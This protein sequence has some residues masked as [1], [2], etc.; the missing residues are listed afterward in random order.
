M[1]V[2]VDRE[3]AERQVELWVRR[4]QPSYRILACYT[5]LPLVLTPELVNYLWLEFLRDVVPWVAG[6]DLLLSELCRPV[7][8]ELYAMDS[9]VRSHLLEVMVQTQDDPD[10]GRYLGRSRLQ[11]V[12][13]KLLSFVKYLEQTEGMNADA[14]EAQQWAA[15]VYLDEYRGQ[16]VQDI[17]AAF[18]RRDAHAVDRS[19]LA[20]LSHITAELAPELQQYPNLVDYARLV[21]QML[22]NPQAVLPEALRIYPV[23]GVELALPPEL[24]PAE[25]PSASLEQSVESNAEAVAGFP[26]LQMVQTD[27]FEAVPLTVEASEEMEEQTPLQLFEFTTATIVRKRSIISQS[28]QWEIQRSQGA[29]WQFVET[30]GNGVELEMV[31]IPGG[32]FM[33]GSPD[34]EPESYDDEKPR[35]EVNVPPFY[36]GKYPVT[37]KQW[38][39]VATLPQVER[40]LTPDPSR[41]KGENLPVEQVSWYDAVEFCQRLSQATGREYRLPSEAEWEYACRAG[42]KTPFYCGETI[43]TELANYDG[44]S[45]YNHGPKGEYRKRTTEVGIFPANP[46][47]LYDLHGNVWEWCLDDWHENYEGAPVDG[48]AWLE[49]YDSKTESPSSD[50]VSKVLRGGSWD[51]DPRYCRSADR[52]F[53]DPA[54]DFN[55]NFGFRVVC[56]SPRTVNS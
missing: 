49:K 39:A 47:G 15:M 40:E 30:L 41:F 13:R 23:E 25:L 33:M 5:A 53:N 14:L 10:W 51:Y 21:A 48:S 55:Y 26:M 54:F 8:Y 46:F 29:A 17:A 52:Y 36:M 19:A 42:T 44:N 27:L 2:T 7:G 22:Q 45:T 3:R 9:A 24:V 18:D 11:A 56:V 38:Q 31:S 28:I 37:Q 4:F 6:V 1:T 16:A 43:T 34:D 32:T 35:H 20:R 12:A 50:S